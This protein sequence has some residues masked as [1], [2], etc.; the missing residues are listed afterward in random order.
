MDLFYREK[1]TRLFYHMLTGL[2]FLLDKYKTVN[3]L[4]GMATI[5]L[6]FNVKSEIH[7]CSSQF[8]VYEM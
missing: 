4:K 2:N 5:Q 8:L 1:L 6:G 3:S 7:S